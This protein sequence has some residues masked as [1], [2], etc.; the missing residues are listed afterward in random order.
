MA[1]VRVGVKPD[2]IRAEQPSHQLL[3]MRQ[4]RNQLGRRKWNLQEETNPCVRQ[5]TAQQ[6][7]QQQE[8]V[9]VN[10][11]QIT[12]AILRGNYISA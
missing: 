4:C 2:Q 7:R 6:R 5:T 12:G 3:A 11:D 8:M 1:H 9:V 10:P